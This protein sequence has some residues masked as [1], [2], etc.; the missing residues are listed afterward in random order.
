MKAKQ[1]RDNFPAL[2]SLFDQFEIPITWATVGH[3]F[4]NEC[5]DGD[6]DWMT[7]VPHFS[8][9]NWNFCQG[10]WFDDDPYGNL[11][12]NKEWY[13]T[14]LIEKILAGKVN[15]ELGC[16]TFSHIDFSDANCPANV[17][18][19]EI[20][21]CSLAA[22]RFDVELKSMVFP[23]GTW[24]NIETLKNNGFLIYRKT[25]NEDLAYPYF[26]NFGLLVTLASLSFGKTHNWSKEFYIKRFKKYIDKAIATGTIAHFWF[27]PS[28]D[29]WTLDNIMP[30]VLEY[31]KT[32]RQKGDLWIGTMG[33]IAEF[34]NENRF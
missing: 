28:L 33:D 20:K 1:A 15:H 5:R 12:L 21:A 13:A 6:H 17:A 26:D 2:L 3:L 22:Q 31:A 24:G 7:P 25:I 10:S 8:N 23:G 16:H 14:D 11:G 4:L 32:Q 18:R 34:I 30:V 29:R 9:K 27:H 19:D